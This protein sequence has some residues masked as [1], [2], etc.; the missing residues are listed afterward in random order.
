MSTAQP[1]VATEV[2]QK[3]DEKTMGVS[4]Q[5]L[6]TAKERFQKQYGLYED[7]NHFMLLVT[8]PIFAENNAR[9]WA[10]LLAG[11]SDLGFQLVIRANASDEYRPVV[12][13]FA[14]DH[15]GLVAVIP[16]DE[17]KDAYE[18][19]DVLLTFSEDS[20]TQKEVLYALEKG[21]VPIVSHSF[22]L[23]Y[24]ENYNPNLENGNCFMYYKHS[25]WSIFA[26]LVRTYE[27][28]RF[29]YDWKNICKSAVQAI[30]SLEL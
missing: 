24:L 19:V 15:P 1:T 9:V 7:K 16:E 4:H 12:E 18:A 23:S 21:V 11:I 3:I 25:P 2:L 28:Y 8:T 5:K 13:S 26:A 20:A 17:Y 22:P 29:P 30:K 14:D 27:N 10:E 6:I